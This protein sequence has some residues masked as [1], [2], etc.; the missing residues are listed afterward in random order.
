MQF[1]TLSSFQ[2]SEDM[3]AGWTFEKRFP[4]GMWEASNIVGG[5][6]RRFTADTK[7]GARKQAA[8]FMRAFRNGEID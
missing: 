3:L 1:Q 4:S 6:L 7:A 8:D 2:R 5:Y